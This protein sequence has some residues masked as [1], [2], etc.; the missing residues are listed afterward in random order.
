MAKVINIIFTLIV[1]LNVQ[2]FGNEMSSKNN[3]SNVEVIENQENIDI[4]SPKKAFYISFIPGYSGSWK[5]E[6]TDIGLLLQIPKIL[7]I[8]GIIGSVAGIIGTT[9]FISNSN[10][11]KE[12]KYELRFWYTIFML[13]STNVYVGSAVGDAIYSKNFVNKY[14][15]QLKLQ[16]KKSKQNHTRNSF[17]FIPYLV[18]DKGLETHTIKVD[19][20]GLC[21][22]YKI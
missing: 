11:R 19:G 7:G 10:D 12:V 17:L 22:T 18:M 5:A 16:L 4:I 14:N 13:L 2:V 3:T 21:F 15:D 9:D 20:L 6:Y 8:A 1:I